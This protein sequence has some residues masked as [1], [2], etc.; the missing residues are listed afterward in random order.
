[1]RRLT[2]KYKAMYEAAKKTEEEANLALIE[3]NDAFR[4]YLEADWRN[5]LTESDYG[6]AY[7]EAINKYYA[8][9]YKVA[10]I[11]RARDRRVTKE[12]IEEEAKKLY[13]KLAYLQITMDALETLGK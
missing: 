11:E 10:A 2:K 9:K 12:T 4:K 8:A 7:C 6:D 1:M 3:A 13:E 5:G